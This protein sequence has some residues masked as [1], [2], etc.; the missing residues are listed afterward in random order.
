MTYEQFKIEITNVVTELI[1]EDSSITLT[2]C[3]KN[4][5]VI[6]DGM[7]IRSKNS[8]ISPTI[9]VNEFYKEYLNGKDL[10][11]IAELILE[12]H[13]Q[14]QMDKEVNS[15]LFM[16]YSP[17]IK[18][19]IV[20]KLINRDKNQELLKT[21]PYVEYMDLAIIFYIYIDD[22]NDG[23][24]SGGMQ[25]RNEFIRLWGID[26]N[27]LMR[28]AMENTPKHLGLRV[29]GVFSTIA[30]YIGDEDFMTIAK[31]E[32]DYTPLLVATNDYA[33]NG[34][35][36]ILYKDLLK[37]VADKLKADL[38]IIPVSVNEVMLAKIIDGFDIKR[39]DL[40]AL[41]HE[42]NMNELKEED[43]LSD[44]LYFYSRANNSLEIV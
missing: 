6:Y 2:P 7:N 32:D 43:I 35:S 1:S 36:V 21:I 25:I 16:T 39:N 19:H 29:R 44:N 41:I 24:Y 12:F 20:F 9:Y 27:E 37:N 5:G 23:E 13:K 3:L 31:E 22:L 8:N 14:R 30:D 34:A 26:V 42:V 28:V 38:Y 11:E 15:D 17:Y 40:K 18:E 10:Q 33:V 4:N